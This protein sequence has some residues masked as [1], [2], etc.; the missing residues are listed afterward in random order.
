[1]P[2]ALQPL[3]P[4]SDADKVTAERFMEFQLAWWAD[5]I[6]FG[7]YPQVM[8]DIVGDRLPVFT[9]EESTLIAGSNDFFGLN[10]YTSW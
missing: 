8:K 5:P 9:E 4:D 10:H 6:Y 3:D 1:M 7:D 2:A